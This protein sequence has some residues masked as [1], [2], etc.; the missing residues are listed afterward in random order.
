MLDNLVKVLHSVLW[1]LEIL[2][3]SHFFALLTVMGR[4][5]RKLRLCS[6]KNYERNKYDRPLVV[7]IPRAK[8]SVMNV[9]IK[10]EVLPSCSIVVSFPI[11]LFRDARVFSVTALQNRLL[12]LKD[13]LPTGLSSSRTL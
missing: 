12:Q 5:H 6:R 13:A 4:G 1:N 2:Y 11:S 7:S 9:S 3:I 10:R 8:V